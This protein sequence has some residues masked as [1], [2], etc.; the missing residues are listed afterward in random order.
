MGASR[1][2]LL[3]LLVGLLCLGPHA[4]IQAQGLDQPDQRDF[5]FPVAQALDALDAEDDP[6]VQG[7]WLAAQLRKLALGIPGDITAWLNVRHADGQRQ[8]HALIKQTKPLNQ[9]WRDVF[10]L[11]D[12]SGVS[13]E[14]LSIDHLPGQVPTYRHLRGDLSA[15][16][17]DAPA[18]LEGAQ[19]MVPFGGSGFWLVDLG[20]DFLH[21]PQQQV[22]PHRIQMRKGVSCQVLE[23]QLN[24]AQDQGYQRVRSWV[25]REHGGIV[26]AEAYNSEGR[27]IKVFEVNDVRKVNDQWYVTELK[28]RD[29]VNRSTSTMVFDPEP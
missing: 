16:E 27:K 6:L 26:Y 18:V 10:V 28:I 19:I 4:F 22:I 24:V 3:S 15:L 23:S 8:Q 29:L 9:G 12:E 17:Q 1:S 11:Q 25:S 2:I 5:S 21:W 13:V 20:L 14:S 7:H